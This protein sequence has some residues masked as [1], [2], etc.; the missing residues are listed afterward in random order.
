MG[1]E[2]SLEQLRSD[3]KEW[4]VQA[5]HLTTEADP[6]AAS[7]GEVPTPRYPDVRDRVVQCAVKNILEPIFEAGFWHVSYGF[8]PGR[9]SHGALEHIRMSMRPRAT[10]EDGRRQRTPYQWVIEGD[11]KGCFDN[12]DHHQLMKRVRA[13]VTDGKVTRLIAQ[14]LKA[15]VLTTASCYRR[16]KAL[17]KV[18]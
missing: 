1:M 9:G 5:E 6:Q 10:A 17:L 3:L 4:P 8:R 11:I 14:F 2:F 18:V 15:G 12:I 16:T 13:R 7:A